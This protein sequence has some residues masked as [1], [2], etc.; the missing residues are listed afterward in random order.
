MSEEK[1]DPMSMSDVMREF[2]S[3]VEQ[4]VNDEEDQELREA[5]LP[6]LE[7]LRD[8]VMESERFLSEYPN[9]AGLFSSMCGII[10]E[11]ETKLELVKDV[12]VSNGLMV[13]VEAETPAE[14]IEMAKK[15]FEE[16]ML[17]RMMANVDKS[18]VH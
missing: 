10:S 18:T 5:L 15:T 17:N 13:Q 12:L 3:F 9:I 1:K 14:A 11:H 4:K 16:D 8:T 2:Y 7:R 6:E